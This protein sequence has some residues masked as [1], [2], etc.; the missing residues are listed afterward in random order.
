M[1]GRRPLD[2]VQGQS[3]TKSPFFP[4]PYANANNQRYGHTSLTYPTVVQRFQR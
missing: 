2:K 4:R 1:S 3:G